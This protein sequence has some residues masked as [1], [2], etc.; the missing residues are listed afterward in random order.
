MWP[1]PKRV[2][3]LKGGPWNGAQYE[4]DKS[5]PLPNYFTPD[6]V[7]Y[8]RVNGWDMEGTFMNDPQKSMRIFPG[9]V[10]IAKHLGDV[11]NG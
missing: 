3:T 11:I 9:T 2:I 4:L 6:G 8:Y 5:L 7:A 1:S 10:R